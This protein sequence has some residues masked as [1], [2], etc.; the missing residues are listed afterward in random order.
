MT[1]APFDPAEINAGGKWMCATARGRSRGVYS[2]GFPGL[3]FFNFG[4][5]LSAARM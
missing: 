5:G 2:Y 1:L 4:A 3:S